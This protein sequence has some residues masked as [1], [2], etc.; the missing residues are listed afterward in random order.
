[1][2][3]PPP[4]ATTTSKSLPPPVMEGSSLSL[5]L[6]LSDATKKKKIEEGQALNAKAK[7]Y[8]ETSMFKW[9][10]DHLGAA[11]LMEKAAE[12]YRAAS[13][14]QNAKQL[15]IEAANSH[16]AC[17]A[18]AAAALAQV[19]GIL[20]TVY[21]FILICLNLLQYIK[22]SLLPFFST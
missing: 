2:P 1:M 21:V 20:Y 14:V 16:E 5:G 13:D 8:L 4:P 10:P 7:K 18:F 15:F 3:P 11:P 22:Q 12:C 9:K 17:N 6:G 19:K